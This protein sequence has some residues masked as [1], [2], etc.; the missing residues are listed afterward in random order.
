M[1]SSFKKSPREQ[2][3]DDTQLPHHNTYKHIGDCY[4][5]GIMDGEAVTNHA[6][7][8]LERDLWRPVTRS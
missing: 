3:Y 4:A 5:Y 2:P 6:E 1:T 7:T 8:S